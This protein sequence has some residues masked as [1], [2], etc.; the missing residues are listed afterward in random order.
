MR[1]A[2]GAGLSEAA[3]AE[4]FSLPVGASGVALADKGGR[5]VLKVTASATP[6]LDP[7]SPALAGA[8]PQLESAMADDLLTQY[9]GGLESQLGVKINQAALRAALGSEQ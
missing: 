8:L 2:G 5:Y 7:N 3:V 1:R 4:V 6:P 9:V